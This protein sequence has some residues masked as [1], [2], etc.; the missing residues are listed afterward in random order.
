[1]SLTEIL[2]SDLNVNITINSNELR[3]F[4]KEVAMSQ[5]QAP[6]EDE[7]YLS[8]DEVCALTKKVRSTLWTWEKRG[9]LKPASRVG[10]VLRYRKSD[11]LNLMNGEAVK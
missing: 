3:G 5:Q 8:V 4:L 2:N 1:M 9:Y 11:V 6:K 10:K 7:Q